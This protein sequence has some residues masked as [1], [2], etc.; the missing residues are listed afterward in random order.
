MPYE[1]IKAKEKFT[2]E[3]ITAI[4]TQ[5]AVPSD[6]PGNTAFAPVRTPWYAQHD[7]ENLM[8]PTQ[9]RHCNS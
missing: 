8:L 5:V 1:S 2:L 7:L 6:A 9:P 3:E 4:N